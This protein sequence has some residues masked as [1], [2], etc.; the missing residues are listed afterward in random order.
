MSDLPAACDVAIVG[1][2]AAGLATAIFALRTADAAGVLARAGRGIERAT[3]Q[4]APPLRR[5]VLLRSC[6]RLAISGAKTSVSGGRAATSPTSTSASAISGAASRPPSGAFSARC[7][8]PTP[9][10]S[11]V[12]SAS[13]STKKRTASSFP[14]PTARATCSTRC[15]A[16]PRRAA[17]CSRRTIA[18]HRASGRGAFGPDGSDNR[19]TDGFRIVADGGELRAAA[20]LA[21][22]RPVVAESGSDGAGLTLATRL[23]QHTRRHCRPHH[24]PLRSRRRR[25]DARRA[26]H[27][28][29][30]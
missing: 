28:H 10:R 17:P 4:L 8:S 22:R 15:F 19:S 1:A 23:G 14:T 11:S 13:R 24:D 12:T 9:S 2:G 5:P 7:P 3:R 26:L 21:D 25:P 20:V 16:R 6:W 27:G 30:A 18:C 29:R